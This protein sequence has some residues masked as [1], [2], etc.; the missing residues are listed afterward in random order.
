MIQL[1]E[2]ANSYEFEDAR[3]VRVYVKGEQEN[4]VLNPDFEQGI[5]FWSAS[6]NGSIA[7]DPTIYPGA[8][9]HGNCINELTILSGTGG[10]ITSDWI[11]VDPGQNYTF[12]GYVSCGYTSDFRT[13]VARIEFS[14]RATVERQ[15]EVITDANGQYLIDDPYYADSETYDLTFHYVHDDTDTT[16]VDP[17]DYPPVSMIPFPNWAGTE[18]LFWEPFAP[19]GFFIAQAIPD[20]IKVEV[21][22][23]TPP[24][25]KDSGSP[26][27]KLTIYFP[28]AQPGDTFWIDGMMLQ[29]TAEGKEYFGGSG[30]NAPANP[31]ESIYFAPADCIWEI[32]NRFNYA[33]NP[34]FE[35]TTDWV[36]V[37]GTLSIVTGGVTPE[38]IVNPNGSLGGL[39]ESA[40]PGV[41]ELFPY[42]PLY[43]AGMG[44]V[45][46]G[47]YG[48]SNPGGQGEISTT[49]YLPRP[50]KGG[51]DFV[52]SVWV[53]GGEGTYT[54]YTNKGLADET[55]RT[56]TVIQHDQYQWIRLYGIRNLT[57]GET[58]FD[59]N[60][61]LEN[62]APS[63]GIPQSN[64]FQL[65][66][67]QAEYGRV[68]TYF[69][70]TLD[71]L[72][73][74][75]P[76]PGNTAK[77]MWMTQVQ[78]N[79]GGKSSYFY[80]YVAKLKRLQANLELVMP[81]GV[82]YAVKP[83]FPTL[84]YQG[85]LTASIIPSA[86][87]EKDLGE[88]V[89]I[90][91][92]L[93]RIQ[94]EGTM[95]EDTTVQGTAYCRV[96]TTKTIASLDNS[97]TIKTGHLPIEEEAGYYAS[98]AIR[99]S[100]DAYGT[101]TLNVTFYGPDDSVIQEYNESISLAATVDPELI[102]PK[103]RWNYVGNV[104]PA[105]EIQGASYAVYT[106]TC[107]PDSFV[108]GQYFDI[109]RCVFRQ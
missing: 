39:V 52:I 17:L 47:T 7:Q 22:A 46:F 15:S 60:I 92:L 2:A 41:P 70:D 20:K 53:R 16:I 10:Y 55:S 109:D 51:E 79:G 49:V 68:P 45:T 73:K 1:A 71:S 81:Y 72:T 97:W 18:P 96:T 99:P 87:F 31:V 105:I 42:G 104:F 84:E 36:D 29:E 9:E 56:L 94:S 82:T 88:W 25:S 38:R 3:R 19:P 78:S 65:D 64:Y 24:Q 62:A 91:S 5:G 102:D 37:Q 40:I 77:T 74:T 26:M 63:F 89:G 54:L 98:A 103:D 83:G 43:G 100:V 93:R 107:E 75:M 66:A 21:S 4:Y 11:S 108:A 32:K 61:L 90:D 13:A 57:Q 12:S 14:N 86:S 101:Y 27:A 67:F 35:T 6:P 59:V 30:A 58:Q 48:V 44:Q 50:A 34:A 28:D 76:N 106:V 33:S 95:A 80:N 85:E 23:I 69:I 8:L